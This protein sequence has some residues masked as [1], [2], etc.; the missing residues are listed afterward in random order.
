[1]TKTSRT[2]PSWVSVEQ[3]GSPSARFNATVHINFCLNFYLVFIHLAC[4]AKFLEFAVHSSLILVDMKD[5][6]VQHS[7]A[8]LREK[9]TKTLLEKNIQIHI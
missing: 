4:K 8:Y 7:E 3:I 1:M 9:S 6:S 5:L 2:Y